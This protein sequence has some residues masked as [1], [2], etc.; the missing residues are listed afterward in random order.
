MPPSLRHPNPWRSFHDN[1]NMQPSRE[2]LMQQTLTAKLKLEVTQEQK[3]QLRVTSLA[4]RTH[5]TSYGA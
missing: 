3:Q 4:Y 5:L 2:T 1:V